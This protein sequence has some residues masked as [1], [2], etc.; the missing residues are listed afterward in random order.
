MQSHPHTATSTSLESL[1]H[2][3]SLRDRA[4]TGGLVL[5]LAAVV[6]VGAFATARHNGWGAN[7]RPAAHLAA[8]R[9]AQPAG[10]PAQT[11]L[12]GV[13]PRASLPPSAP[14]VYLVDSARQ[15]TDDQTE[16]AAASLITRVAQTPASTVTIVAPDEAA[17]VFQAVADENQTRAALHLPEIVVVDLRPDQ[18][19]AD[20]AKLA[21]RQAIADENQLRASLGLPELP[22][23]Q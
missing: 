3:D 5:A 2:G 14:T 6:T 16:L 15:A 12:T 17:E 1:N 21:A 7:A 23:A 8:V 20:S 9:A 18:D 10:S 4:R 22:A 13:V 19:T 11:A